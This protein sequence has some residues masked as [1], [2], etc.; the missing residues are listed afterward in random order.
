M[1][2]TDINFNDML[3]ART[4]PNCETPGDRYSDAYLCESYEYYGQFHI[5]EKCILIKLTNMVEELKND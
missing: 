1:N 5:S 4:C 3:G 2:S